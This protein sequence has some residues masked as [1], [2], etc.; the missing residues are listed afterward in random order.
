M[1][2]SRFKDTVSAILVIAVFTSCASQ[3]KISKK[4]TK[5]FEQDSIFK[6]AF[7]GVSVFNTTTNQYLYNF[8]GTK[9]FVPASNI[10]LPT[11]YAGLKYLGKNLPGLKYAE[12]NDTL[13]LQPTGDPTFLHT[14][15]KQHPVYYFLKQTTKTIIISDAS[16]KAEALGYGWAWDDYLGYYM[17]E[18]SPMP[19]YGN[20]IKWIQ[21]RTVENKN[22]VKDTSFMVFTDPEI[23]WE[24]KI[25]DKRSATFDVNR[26]RTENKYTIAEG[27]EMKREL[28]IPFVTNGILSAQ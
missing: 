11:L 1:I 17:A 25:L 10:K 12:Q 19:I 7:V 15:Y 20:T 16:W 2:F 4:I 5:A 28:E 9:Y 21:Q 22:G 13:F 14:D 26:P 24:V 8:N 18:R 23:N 3:Q 27:K 6:N